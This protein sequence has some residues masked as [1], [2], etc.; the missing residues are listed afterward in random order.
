MPVYIRCVFRICWYT[1]GII[2]P[3]QYTDL[4]LNKNFKQ[5]WN[6]FFSFRKMQNSRIFLIR[7]V[8]FRWNNLWLMLV[9]SSLFTRKFAVVI[10]RPE[11]T[12]FD[13]TSLSYFVKLL[14]YSLFTQTH[15]YPKNSYLCFQ[16]CILRG[17]Y[18]RKTKIIIIII[19]IRPSYP[20]VVKI[21]S[22]YNTI[23]STW[24]RL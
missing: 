12:I 20:S 8:A 19:I 24:W 7:V 16:A 2:A 22:L 10:L 14:S 18:G 21:S 13:S 17:Y 9:L 15:S 3:Y 6:N 23:F 4:V 11:I 1:V 5:L